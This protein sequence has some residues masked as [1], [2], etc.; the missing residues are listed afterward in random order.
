MGA[1]AISSLLFCLFSFLFGVAMAAMHAALYA[2][3]SALHLL[4]SVTERS[5]K[6]FVP[7]AEQAT[8]APDQGYKK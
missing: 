5:A 8:P 7:D 6:K 4:P 1:T 3:L 2:V